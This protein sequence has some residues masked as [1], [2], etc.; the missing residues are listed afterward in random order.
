[1]LNTSD[2]ECKKHFCETTPDSSCRSVERLLVNCTAI[3]LFGN[4][5][6]A[7]V[8]KLL[9]VENGSTCNEHLNKEY[10]PFVHTYRDVGHIHRGH[11]TL[12]SS[13]GSN[14]YYMHQN[15][16]T[17]EGSRSTKLRVVFDAPYKTAT[18]ISVNDKQ[19][20]DLHCIV[21]RWHLAKVYMHVAAN[22]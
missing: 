21:F 12:R 14:S 4:F 8:S 11:S 5:P 7:I 6:K 9:Q 19:R 10:S 17:T 3:T 18:G 2:E 1:M 13:N 22:I 16:V 20:D 15:C